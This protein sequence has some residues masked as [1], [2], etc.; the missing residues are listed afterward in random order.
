MNDGKKLISIEE[1]RRRKPSTDSLM[2]DLKTTIAS[3]PE[4]KAK[5]AKTAKTAKTL[6]NPAPKSSDPYGYFEYRGKKYENKGDGWK[7]I[8]PDGSRKNAY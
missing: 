3:I 1:F 8:Q 2:A 6:D 7:I 5:K 4:K